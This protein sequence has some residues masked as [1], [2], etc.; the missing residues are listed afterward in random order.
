MAVFFGWRLHIF[1]DDDSIWRIMHHARWRNVCMMYNNIHRQHNHHHHHH[2][3]FYHRCHHH[4]SNFINL[5]EVC[6]RG[7]PVS[8]ETPR[9][10][11]CQQAWA[12]SE[13]EGKSSCRLAHA[14]GTKCSLHHLVDSWL[15]PPPT[16]N[17]TCSFHT[18]SIILSLS[19]LS[20][21]LSPLPLIFYYHLSSILS[22]SYHHHHSSLHYNHRDNIII[23]TLHIN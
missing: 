6:H 15:L 11:L 14:G 8:V 12:F 5:K 3:D 10:P 21:L 4:R 9:R 16:N 2:H 7:P 18:S 19:L 22:S 17:R 20:P 13:E 1:Y 23:V